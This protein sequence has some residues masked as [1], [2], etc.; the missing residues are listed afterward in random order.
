MSAADHTPQQADRDRLGLEPHE[1]QDHDADAPEAFTKYPFYADVVPSGSVAAAAD[2]PNLVKTRQREDFVEAH[3]S[4]QQLKPGTPKRL[5]GAS[6]KYSI[7]RTLTEFGRDQCTD[8][9]AGL[10]YYAVLSVFP[11][12][13][14]F[15]S[16]LSLVGEAQR[17]QQFLLDTLDQMVEAEFMETIET[18]VDQVTAAPGAGL[19]LAVG[20]LIALWT[21]SNYVNAF[22]RAMNR[23]HNAEE[24]RS[25]LKLRPLLYGVTAALI[26]LVASAALMLVVSGPLAEAIGSTVGLGETAVTVWNW[27]TPVVLLL[28]A[29]VGIALLYY[30]TPNS[31]QPGAKWISA[32]ALLA[33]VV[34]VLAT[35]G[36]GVYISNFANY[37][38]TY[39]ALAGVIIFLFW[40][41]IMNVVLLL[42]AEFDAELERARQL[43][44]G[45]E[46]ERT[47]MLA[48]RGTAG[49]YKRHEKYEEVVAAGK[50]LR[51]SAGKTADPDELWRR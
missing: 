35:V 39:G 30:V 41:Y 18:V 7:R 46:A 47:L 13:I 38:A 51:L 6:W 43:Q 21:A 31:R 5:T 36:V 33:I 4:A 20:I 37:E 45:I 27:A 17:T 25:F 16:L 50:A 8:L 29:A 34:M 14:A 1:L 15:V 12:L 42:G 40:I 9:A 3:G 11:A 26:I 22:S 10:T 19:G 23:I 32:G 49:V 2:E 48:P 28:V 24:G 44:G